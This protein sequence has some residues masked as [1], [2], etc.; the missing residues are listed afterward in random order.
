MWVSGVLKVSGSFVSLLLDSYKSSFNLRLAPL[1]GV[2]IYSYSDMKKKRLSLHY[3]CFYFLINLKNFSEVPINRFI[4]L[5]NRTE[6]CPIGQNY[7]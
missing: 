3:I 1:L 2:K 6:L 5:S 7:A 4:F